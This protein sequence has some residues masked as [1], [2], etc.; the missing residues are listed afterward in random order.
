MLVVMA[1]A[2]VPCLVL[3]LHLVRSRGTCSGM[4]CISHVLRSV[5]LIPDISSQC[6]LLLV[7]GVCVGPEP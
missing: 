2:G 6:H 7:S 1:A 4:P 5:Y 3:P